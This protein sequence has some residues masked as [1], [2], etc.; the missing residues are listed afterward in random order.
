MTCLRATVL[1]F[2]ALLALMPVAARAADPLARAQVETQGQIVVGQQVTLRVDVLVPNFFMSSPGFPEL[3]LPNAV[4]TLQDGAQ[5]LVETIDGAAY[6]GIRRTYLITPQAAGEYTL[7]EVQ[8][9]FTY[10]AVPGQPPANGSVTLPTI[11]FTVGGAPGSGSGGAVAARVT[12]NQFV[13]G[14]LKNLKVGDAIVRTVTVTA[15]GIQAMMIPP[16]D[17]EAPEGVRLYRQDPVLAN[18]TDPRQGPATASRIDR[19]TYTFEKAG[20]FTLPAVEI[21]WYDP[22]SAKNEVAS[23]HEIAVDVAAQQAF[24]P[25]IAPPAEAP[26]QP[27]SRRDWLWPAIWIAAALLGATL[28]AWAAARLWPRLDAWRRERRSEHENSEAAYFQR[29]RR[30]CAAGNAKAAF[31]AVDAWSRRA[32]TAPL[33]QWLQHFGDPSVQH[34]YE[35]LERVLFAS[36]AKET[37]TDLP[38]L[39]RGISS[40]RHRWRRRGNVSAPRLP[41]LPELNP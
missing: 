37:S 15:E 2:A 18:D 40:A 1:L 33:P 12:I 27:A 26:A 25:A 16:P 34:Q 38:G 24:E 19:V 3:D 31:A 41:A 4:V 39:G 32:G 35:R 36:G 29:F 11:T 8:I 9:T 30:A 23:A 10:A 22:A 13:E 20:A 6:A 7:P 14:D 17:F 28:L 5:N 21:G